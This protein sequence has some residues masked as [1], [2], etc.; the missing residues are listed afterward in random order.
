MPE[1]R[2]DRT[3]AA[4]W[5]LVDGRGR[6]RAARDRRRFGRCR[7]GRRTAVR[8]GWSEVVVGRRRRGGGA[9]AGSTGRDSR[10]EVARRQSGSRRR[11][12]E[13]GAQGGDPGRQLLIA[14]IGA[15]KLLV[16]GERLLAEPLL[17]VQFGHRLGDEWLVLRKWFG[18]PCF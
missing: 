11:R 18:R 9:L 7:C 10:E 13:L 8:R 16:D 12:G 5:R 3:S 14:R 17:Q 15:E 2:V 6:R 4:L 1:Q